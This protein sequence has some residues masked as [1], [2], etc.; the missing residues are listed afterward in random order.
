MRARA[1][2]FSKL[3]EE[4]DGASAAVEAFHRHLPPELPIPRAA[5]EQPADPLRWFLTLLQKWC[6]LPW[7]P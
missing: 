5:A 1:A 6:C 3:I 7:V 4:E 2:E